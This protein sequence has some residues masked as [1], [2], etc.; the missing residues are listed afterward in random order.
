[1]KRFL[2]VFLLG[3]VALVQA[4]SNCSRYDNIALKNVNGVT[5]VIPNAAIQVC[6]QAASG[7]PCSP[8]IPIY[9]DVFCSVLLSGGGVTTADSNGNFHFYAPPQT[10]KYQVSAIGLTVT[11][12]DDVIL[13]PSPTTPIF[14]GSVTAPFFIDRSL[15]PA[16]IGILRVG[17]NTEAVVSRD[18]FNL[19]DI[20]LLSLGLSNQ[21]FLGPSGG[22]TPVDVGGCISLGTVYDV[23][24]CRTGLATL[25]VGN[26]I[27]GNSSGTVVASTLTTTTL[28][29]SGTANGG[30]FSGA[31]LQN[32]KMASGSTLQDSTGTYSMSMT[33]AKGNGVRDYTTSS[34]TFVD[35]DTVNLAHTVTIP[36]GWKLSIVAS[37]TGYITG[38]FAAISFGLFDTASSSILVEIASN[39]AAVNTADTLSLAYV[40]TGDN[41][42][43]TI[44]LQFHTYNAS[45]PVSLTNNTISS[46]PTMI[47]T[48]MPSS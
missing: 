35:V 11:E 9:S 18:S 26:G 8:V 22:T 43:H 33:L 17:N 36:I 45:D 5:S 34:T 29:L 3:A 15:S 1:M 14:T 25:T 20:S 39:P 42:S 31:T 38:G 7:V 41:A 23:G 6:T 13:A 19:S 27:T 37:G 40:I 47:F 16:Q 12:L 32:P 21:L 28:N 2:A 44:K 46:V 4:Q 24:I 10:F 48:L 30:T